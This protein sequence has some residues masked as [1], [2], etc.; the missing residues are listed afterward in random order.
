MKNSNAVT[1]ILS[2]ALTMSAMIA[3]MFVGVAAQAGEAQA[4]TCSTMYGQAGLI[5]KG[6][7]DDFGKFSFRMKNGRVHATQTLLLDADTANKAELQVSTV[8]THQGKVTGLDVAIYDSN[9]SPDDPTLVAS[10]RTDSLVVGP[11]LTAV[12][13]RNFVVVSCSL[14]KTK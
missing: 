12:I 2:K 13:G 5:Y 6:T 14:E 4:V 9:T 3:A 10:V 7:V 8:E 1:K 11:S